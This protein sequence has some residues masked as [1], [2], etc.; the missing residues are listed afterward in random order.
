MHNKWK[1]LL[2]AE[3]Q[4][5]QGVCIAAYKTDEFPAFFTETSGYKVY[6]YTI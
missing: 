4:E 2:F 1:K 3:L 6:I 5:T